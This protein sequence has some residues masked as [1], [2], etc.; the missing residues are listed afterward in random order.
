MEEAPTENLA[1]YVC[2]A[3]FM[4]ALP[5]ETLPHELIWATVPPSPSTHRQE[6]VA[7]GAA[8][9]HIR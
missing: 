9:G 4:P 1:V 8:V 7:E 2:P 5:H 6:Q 3:E